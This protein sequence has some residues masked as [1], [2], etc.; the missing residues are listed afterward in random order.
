MAGLVCPRPLAAGAL[1]GVGH[2]TNIEAAK[3]FNAEIRTFLRPSQ[4]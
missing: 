1:P 4:S 2:P 3:R